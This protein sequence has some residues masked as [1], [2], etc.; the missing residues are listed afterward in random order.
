MDLGAETLQLLAETLPRDPGVAP[1]PER[2][3]AAVLVPLFLADGELRVVLTKR[4]SHMRRHR[5]EVS[6]P[7]GAS[8]PADVSLAATALRETF[9]EIG[10]QPSDVELIGVLQDMPTAGSGYVIRPFVAT[11]PHP[12]DYVPD[13]REVERIFTPGLAEF[14]DPALRRD[15][16]WE[17]D[18]VRYPVTFFDVDGEVV[19]GATARMLVELL[20]VIAGRPTAPLPPIPLPERDR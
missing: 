12:Y 2:R 20:D 6:F 9:E 17:R 18:G 14:A 11:V 16:V 19:W 7:G 10:L 15:E 8:E 1:D 5:G 13:P 4:T 3:S